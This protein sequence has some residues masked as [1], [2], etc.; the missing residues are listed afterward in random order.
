VLFSQFEVRG[1]ADRLLIYLTLFTQQALERLN[2]APNRSEVR[3]SV[4]AMS[5][6]S[7][8]TLCMC[9][10]HAGQQAHELARH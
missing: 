2:K 8:T 4:A 6:S 9:R 7:F 1:N 3:A 5:C 10:T